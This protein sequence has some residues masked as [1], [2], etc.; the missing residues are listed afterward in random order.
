VGRVWVMMGSG[1]GGG[2][3]GSLGIGERLVVGFHEQLWEY[4]AQ[5]TIVANIVILVDAC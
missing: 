4:P 3:R 2:M 1:L 5:H